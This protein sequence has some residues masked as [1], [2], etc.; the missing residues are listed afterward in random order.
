MSLFNFFKKKNNDTLADQQT[1]KQENIEKNKENIQQNKNQSVSGKN[2]VGFPL[3]K[4]IKFNKKEF[5]SNFKKYWNIDLVEESNKEDILTFYVGNTLV[6]VSLMPAPIPNKEAEKNAPYNFMWKDAL[7]QVEK[8]KAHLLVAVLGNTTI[9]EKSIIF[10]KVLSTICKS[11]NTLAIYLNSITYE[12]SFYFKC[13]D[14]I[15]SEEFP[16]YNLVWFGLYKNNDNINC[17][18]TIGM[19]NFNKD[20]IEVLGGNIEFRKIQDFTMNVA[21][22]VITQNITLKEGETI[23]FTEK[24]KCKISY[25][26]GLI[27]PINTLKI[28]MI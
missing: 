5:K 25:G 22:Y 15:N 18:Y 10:V 20:E 27:L 1:N 19:N 17:S 4:E 2:L 11:E 24:Q 3:L 9:I 28:E 12:P 6:T 26:K 21:N 16:I 7:K 8:H 13:A 23:G 14:M